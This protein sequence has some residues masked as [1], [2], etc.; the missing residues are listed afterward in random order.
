M[1]QYITLIALV[2][3]TSCS[4]SQL[5]LY[6]I[7][8][9]GLLSTF[10]LTKSGNNY[11]GNF[12]YD[13]D[14]DRLIKVKGF[15]ENNRLVLNEYNED[16]EITGTF[17]GTFDESIYNGNWI[18]PDKSINIPFNYSINK[19]SNL[20]TILVKE[21]KVYELKINL[22][23]QKWITNKIETGEYWTEETYNEKA[24][25]NRQKNVYWS[26]DGEEET[27]I[28]KQ[29]I[30]NE[31]NDPNYIDINNDGILD[32]ISYVRW[33]YCEPGNWS[34]TV[35][36]ELLIFISDGESYKIFENPKQIETG[37]FFKRL[38][39]NKELEFDNYR[40]DD[41]DERCCPSIQ[42]FT[43]YKFVDNDF[44]FVRKT[45][46]SKEE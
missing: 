27:G 20:P 28:C 19:N 35:P 29:G 39:E 10:E 34:A 3:L 33:L 41:D 12:Y 36:S 18:S 17:N 16:L 40:Y 4:K 21:D 31:F 46:E 5:N 26:I 43:Y 15:F 37:G 44:V 8:G 14:I 30:P 24:E 22:A 7:I 13:N 38:T 23:Y 9:N 1:K 32:C 42:W 2:F 25:I 11:S 6:G 45:D